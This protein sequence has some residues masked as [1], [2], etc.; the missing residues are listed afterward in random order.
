MRFTMEGYGTG[1][2]HQTLNCS[3]DVSDETVTFGAEAIRFGGRSP[4][5][6]PGLIMRGTTD[7]QAITDNDVSVLLYGLSSAEA[8]I[9]ARKLLEY[10]SH[11]AT[12]EG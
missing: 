2:G 3:F 8:V 9:L 6:E 10:A 4:V 12:A 11:L 5:F 1:P 7:K